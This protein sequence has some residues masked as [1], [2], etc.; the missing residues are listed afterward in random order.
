[1]KK[2]KREKS[3]TTTG[4]YVR[5][6]DLLPAVIEAKQLGVVTDKLIS[7]IQM[8]AERYSRK[9]S[10]GG[11]SFREDMVSSAI[12]NLCKNALKFNHERFNNPFAFYTTAIHNSFL[13]YM[14]DEKKHRNIRDKLLL[15]AGQ[16]PSFNYLDKEKDEDSSGVKESDEISIEIVEHADNP[17]NNQEDDTVKKESDGEVE[18]KVIIKESK[19]GYRDRAPGPVIRYGPG[20]FDV[21]PITGAFILKKKEALIAVANKTVVKEDKTVIE[22]TAKPKAVA[23]KTAVKAVAKKTVVKAVAKK[24][25][26]SAKPKVTAVTKKTAVKKPAAKVVVKKQAV[27]KAEAKKPVVKKIQKPSSKS[28]KEK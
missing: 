23:K 13:Q 9:G 16:N 24:T 1:M 21:D 15:D 4:H 18:E 20:D 27:K 3:T 12:E 22:K 10:F 5:N 19:I 8:I 17:E 11:Y 14:A 26:T 25:A 6:A 28:K 2:I 7:M